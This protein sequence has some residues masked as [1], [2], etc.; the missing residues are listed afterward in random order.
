VGGWLLID[1]LGSPTGEGTPAGQD[2]SPTVEQGSFDETRS[3][4]TGGQTAPVNPLARILLASLS[5]TVERPLFNQSRAPKPE[6]V[7]EAEPKEE[8]QPSVADFTLL[9]IA[10]ANND[11]TALLRLNKT[12]EV[13]RLKAGQNFAEWKVTDIQARSVVIGNGETA[14]SL[15][16]FTQLAQP[17]QP[18]EPSSDPAPS[19][20]EDEDEGTEV[21]SELNNG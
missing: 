12:N 11:R 17:L 10:V 14:F 3:L 5:Q 20:E 7:A 8:S 9:G 21:V 4:D 16:L 18:S 6:P 13:V 19:D 2:A 15:E 1:L